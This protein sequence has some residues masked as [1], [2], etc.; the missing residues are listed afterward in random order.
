MK[1]FEANAVQYKRT[2]TTNIGRWSFWLRGFT[3]I[4]D[5][6][7]AVKWT[8]VL[9]VLLLRNTTCFRCKINLFL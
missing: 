2:N 5:L 3:V 1:C 7:Q 8:T 6:I 4:T 9:L